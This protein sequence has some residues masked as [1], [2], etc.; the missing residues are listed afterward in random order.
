MS[1]LTY[2]ADLDGLRAVAVMSV[3]VFHA[4]PSVVR[5]GFVGVDV[6]F[7][8]SGYLISTIIFTGLEQGTFSFWNFYARRVKRIFPA[9]V[10]VLATILAFGYFWLLDDE[11]ASVGKHVAAGA[12]FVANFALWQ[13]SGYFDAAAHSKP[14]LHLWSLGIEEQFYIL[15]P[16]VVWLC[17][18]SQLGLLIAPVAIVCVSVAANMLHTEADRVAAFYSPLTRFWELSAG[19]LLAYLTLRRHVDPTRT[20]VRKS[21]VLGLGGAVLLTGAVM[22]TPEDRFPGWWAVLP[23]VGAAAVIAA[24]E[25]S[26]INRHVLAHKVAVWFGLISYPLYLWH[27]PILSFARITTQSLSV[28]VG[29]IVASTILAWL[30]YRFV[31]QRIRGSAGVGV[32]GLLLCGGVTVGAL[33]AYVNLRDG[34][35]ERPVVLASGLSAAVRR[36]F[37]GPNWAYM[38]NRTCLD[39]YPFADGGPMG[40]WFCIKSDTRPPTLLLMGNSFANQLYP[41]FAQ[42]PLLQ[43]HTIL[44]IG[45]CDFVLTGGARNDP[46]PCYGGYG[47]KEETFINELVGR[48]SSIRFAVID[49]LRA[50]PDQVY[51]GRLQDRVDALQRRGI[52]VVVFTPHLKPNFDP[53][54]CYAIPPRQ[55]AADCTF[56]V[57]VR[58]AVLDGFKP[59]IDGLAESRS[60]VQVFDQ[61]SIFCNADRCSYLADGMPLHRDSVHI[62]EFASVALQQP[63]ND[64]ARVQIPQIF[65]PGAIGR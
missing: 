3:V 20:S 16:L 21:T 11:Y 22:F 27:W 45:S 18:K 8:I 53:K 64:W 61:N 56:P 15:W 40:Y 65:D 52:Q 12:G 38:T 32:A 26:W 28:R 44:S 35:A 58:Q 4:F 54:L 62:S 31:E 2:R 49:G 5:G 47:V 60:P 57:A 36:Q 39:A 55:S 30:T 7:V 46:N 10:L 37:T 33:G 48:E 14:L 1:Q 24:G 6:F 41:G 29:G 50:R 9:L 43:H 25:G 51:L 63:F 19:G 42:N 23:V 17:W 13:E 34:L 59:A